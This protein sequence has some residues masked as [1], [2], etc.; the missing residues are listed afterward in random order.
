MNMQTGPAQIVK[1][2]VTERAQHLT[3]LRHRDALLAGSDRPTVEVLGVFRQPVEPA[4]LVIEPGS[5]RGIAVRQIETSDKQAADRRFDVAAVRV[6][7][8]ARRT[9][10][11]F[12]RL[13]AARQ[14]RYAVPAFLPMPDRAVAGSADRSLGKLLVRRRQL[15]K[16]DDVRRGLFQPLEGWRGVR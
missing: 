4:Q 9:P 16:T 11:D 15:L 10:T 5:G 14:N 3:L 2:D 12:H 8:I 6:V 13:G 1:G 7:G